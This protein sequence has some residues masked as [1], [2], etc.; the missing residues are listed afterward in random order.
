M[1]AN[2][3]L[4]LAYESLQ[5]LNIAVKFHDRHLE[6]AKSS[7]NVFQENEAHGALVRV[8]MQHGKDL[9]KRGDWDAALELYSRALRSAKASGDSQAEGAAK[10]RVGRSL[11]MVDRSEDALP[12]LEQYLEYTQQPNADD[13]LDHDAQGQAFAALATAHQGVGN[14]DAALDC[15]GEYL[16]I[17]ELTED[18]EAQAEACKNLGEMCNRYVRQ[19]RPS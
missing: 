17:A 1:D 8:C 9:D 16:R 15:L 3:H 12:Y 4:G 11:V 6:L 10:Y 19:G 13:E 5:E 14:T 7:A 2:H 18:L